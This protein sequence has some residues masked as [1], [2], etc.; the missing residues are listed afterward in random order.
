MAATVFFLDPLPEVGAVA[1]LDGP[2]GRHAATVRRIG[3][4]ERLVLSDG[5]GEVADGELVGAAKDRLDVRIDG[6]R[7]LP[8]ATPTV[9][10]VQ[11]LP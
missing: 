7:S 1:V 5:R 8:V 11:A 10:V 3:V 2:E 4:G 6:R 9:T